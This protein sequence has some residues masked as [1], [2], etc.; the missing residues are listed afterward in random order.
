MKPSTETASRGR[1][2]SKLPNPTQLDLFFRHFIP[3]LK[4]TSL[5]KDTV[6]KHL[7]FIPYDVLV[8]LFVGQI[9]LPVWAA[10]ALVAVN[11]GTWWCYHRIPQFLR[12]VS[13]PDGEGILISGPIVEN[14]ARFIHSCG[15]HHR[16]HYGLMF[17]MM[18]GFH[19]SMTGGLWGLSISSGT[20]QI[21]AWSSYA[22]L[23]FIDFVM[24]WVSL[25]TLQELREDKLREANRYT[26]EL[27]RSNEELEQFAYIASHDL[28][29]PLRAI[30][31]L[32]K[33]IE[34][35]IGENCS[36]ET[37]EHLALLQTRTQRMDNLLQDLLRYARI[38]RDETTM[39]RIDLYEM[40]RDIFESHQIE[41]TLHLVV[42]G[43]RV[44]VTDYE[45]TYFLLL[46][47]L[48][49]NAIKHHDKPE[50]QIVVTFEPKKEHLVIIVED[51]GPG[52]PAEYRQKVFEV[53]TTLD[54]RD[55]KEAAGMGLAIVRKIIHHKKGK[56]VLDE[57]DSGGARFVI[58]L[59]LVPAG[60]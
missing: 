45:I 2:A 8:V 27:K 5:S 19:A 31:N 40:V 58:T 44:Q 13:E 59:P 47:N 39:D 16:A 6:L 10:L 26:N 48:I 34:H 37:R 15:V 42:K 36:P 24:Y 49:G 60:V 1:V 18:A 30:I 23:L 50:G 32:S 55:Q 43:P 7:R 56:I 38:G 51:D 35:D 41:N 12:R 28:R 21:L 29:A 57:N 3:K 14:F 46:S 22:A 20:L 33:W 53:F 52:I 4:V 17:A 11:V 25:R 54:R 9:M